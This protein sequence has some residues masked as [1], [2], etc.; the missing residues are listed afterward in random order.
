MDTLMSCL[1][2]PKSG[3]ILNGGPQTARFDLKWAGPVKLP[4]TVN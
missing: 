3:V 4:V 1:L 2:V